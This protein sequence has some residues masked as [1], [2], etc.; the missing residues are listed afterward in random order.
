MRRAA[1]GAV[2]VASR[3]MCDVQ[4]PIKD[5]IP[6]TARMCTSSAAAPFPQ[7]GSKA[8]ERSEHW[9]QNI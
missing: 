8:Q 5:A 9:E 7:R 1:A 6:T 4:A 3:S 2:P